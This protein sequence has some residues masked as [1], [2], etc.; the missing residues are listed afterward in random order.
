[1]NEGFEH[2]TRQATGPAELIVKVKVSSEGRVEKEKMTETSS[3][4]T[5][6]KGSVLWTKFSLLSVA[7][8]TKG[9]GDYGGVVS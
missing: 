9:H 8:P 7:S 2:P 4:I 5:G 6:S 1:M 3:M